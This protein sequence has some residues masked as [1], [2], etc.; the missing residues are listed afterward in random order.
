MAEDKE[1]LSKAKTTSEECSSMLKKNNF[2]GVLTYIGKNPPN[3]KDADIHKQIGESVLEALRSIKKDQ[4]NILDEIEEHEREVLLKYVY[5]GFQAK[6]E[7][8][9][10]YLTWHQAIVK[11]DGLGAIVRVLT[12]IKRNIL[13]VGQG[14]K[15]DAEELKADDD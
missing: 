3:C 11:K 7:Y 9:Q 10:E 2:R 5:Y 14:T 15:E 1:D 13:V 4:S 12:D 8:A 6:P